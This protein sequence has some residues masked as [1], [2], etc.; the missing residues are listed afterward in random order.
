[1]PNA[2]VQL[3][4]NSEH[5]FACSQYDVPPMSHD[6]KRLASSCVTCSLVKRGMF[7]GNC[8]K[9][10]IFVYPAVAFRERMKRA[11]GQKGRHAQ[12]TKRQTCP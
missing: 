9:L 10:A 2:N 6:G 11:V 8:F 3:N 7:C 5:L 1:M 4:V 12:A